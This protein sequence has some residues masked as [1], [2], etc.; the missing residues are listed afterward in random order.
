MLFLPCL[1]AGCKGIQPAQN[2]NGWSC[3]NSVSMELIVRYIEHFH[4]PD[5]QTTISLVRHCSPSA[6][7]YSSPCNIVHASWLPS[8]QST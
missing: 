7:Y 5:Q 3:R 4:L 2:E 1:K 8:S 6:L